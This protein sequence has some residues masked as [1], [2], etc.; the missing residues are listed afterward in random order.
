MKNK[1]V[2]YLLIVACSFVQT[3]DVSLSE[4]AL[5]LSAKEPFVIFHAP[6][7]QEEV[8][9]LENLRVA[10]NEQIASRNITEFSSKV[11]DFLQTQ[12]N[13]KQAAQEGSR[14]ILK[15]IAQSR[16]SFSGSGKI[17]LMLQ[18]FSHED[19]DFDSSVPDWHIDSYS[20]RDSRIIYALRGQGTLFSLLPNAKRPEF[21][22]RHGNICK[23]TSPTLKNEFL[24]PYGS[25]SPEAGQGAMFLVGNSGEA[26]IHAVPLIN[27][28]R[29]VLLIDQK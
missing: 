27:R 16:L 1:I 3:R 25:I 22:D 26:A 2:T 7:T 5:L 28:D 24:K 10:S 15:L 20:G 9:F 29:L 13:D 17:S 4:K 11:Y 8:Q 18:S 12:G 21:L 6:I 23:I 19:L 14:I